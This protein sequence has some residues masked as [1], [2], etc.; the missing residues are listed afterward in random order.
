MTEIV[1]PKN[2]LVM[3]CGPAGCGKSTFAARNF[4]STQIVSSDECRAFISDDATNQRVSNHAFDL[5]H[6]IIRKRLL[7]GRLTVADATHLKPEERRPLKMMAR[8]FG[9]HSVALLFDV[10][11][12]VCLT[13]NAARSRIVPPEAVRTQYHLFES[14]MDEIS[15]E[16]FDLV[17]ILDE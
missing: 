11:L 7:I 4:L 1:I 14:T 12:D 15:G 16:G 17:F 13:R 2:S 5:M 8:R 9:Y 3:L 6:F 10:S